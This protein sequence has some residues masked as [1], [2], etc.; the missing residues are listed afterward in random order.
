[1]GV[2][3]APTFSTVI[4]PG[5]VNWRNVNISDDLMSDDSDDRWREKN[6]GHFEK[7]FSYLSDVYVLYVFV[8]VTS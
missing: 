3:E 1:M 4:Q 2:E 7:K 5:D 6:E 8:C